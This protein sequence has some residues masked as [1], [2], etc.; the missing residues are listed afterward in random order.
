MRLLKRMEK[1]IKDPDRG[2]LR[3]FE[4]LDE[5]PV[6]VM[7]FGIEHFDVVSS[8]DDADALTRM[9]LHGFVPS[10][11]PIPILSQIDGFPILKPTR[12]DRIALHSIDR[13]RVRFFNTVNQHLVR[14]AT[15]ADRKEFGKRI[16]PGN[17][18]KFAYR[19]HA[20]VDRYRDE[21]AFDGSHGPSYGSGRLW[22]KSPLFH[23]KKAKGGTAETIPPLDVPLAPMPYRTAPCL[24][25]P[26]QTLPDRT[27]PNRTQ[28]RLSEL[29]EV[30]NAR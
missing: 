2:F 6:F 1:P 24:T 23:P 15:I 17:L 14:A 26:S 9:E 22:V 30:V 3:S 29:L 18:V 13:I 4:R 28:A 16:G 21:N 27:T 25:L 20:E 10:D 11:H 5:G 7:D 12:H 8:L 19:G